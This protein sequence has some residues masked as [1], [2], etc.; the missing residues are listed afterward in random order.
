[1][2]R[3]AL[4]VVF[5]VLVASW[6]PATAQVLPVPPGSAAAGQGQTDPAPPSPPQA[7]PT[8]ASPATIDLNEVPV[9]LERSVRVVRRVTRG[10][11]ADIDQIRRRMP[12]LALGLRAV[13][14]QNQEELR[15]NRSTVVVR[16]LRDLWRMAD[17]LLQN[18]QSTLLE[19]S[20]T[21]E[22]DIATLGEEARYLSA[23]QEILAAENVDSETL[24]TI[25]RVKT[26]IATA[27]ALARDYRNELLGLEAQ[28]A[29]LAIEI[30]L[31]EEELGEIAAAERMGMLRL[32]APP[33]WRRVSPEPQP[34][35]AG[36]PV[37]PAA[38]GT[39]EGGLSD[40]ERAALLLALDYALTSLLLTLAMYVVFLVPF[41]LIRRHASEWIDSD[42]PAV[43]NLGRALERPYSAALLPA[44]MTL[45]ISQGRIELDSLILLLPL[46]RV[47]PRLLPPDYTRALW[48]LAG[49]TVLDAIARVV[50][51]ESAFPAR[52]TE[53]ALIG[54]TAYGLRWL[55]GQLG[56]SA[57][58]RYR[59]AVAG[60]RVALVLLGVAF[61]SEVIGATLLAGYLEN[62]VLKGTYGAV[63]LYGF[64]QMFRGFLDLLIRSSP[65]RLGA[66]MQ[67]APTGLAEKLNAGMR[68]V[69]LVFF[70]LLLIEVFRFTDPLLA[71]GESVMAETLSVGELQFTVGAVFIVI[72]TLVVAAVVSSVLRFFLTAVVYDRMALQRGTGE[73]ISKLL[74]YALLTAGFLFALGAAGIDLNSIAFLVGALGVGIGLG[75]QNIVGNF[76]SGLIL[77]FER[78]LNVGDI[79]SVG[80]VAGAV[81]DIGIRATRIRT[82]DG[83]DVAVPNSTLIS[84]EFTNWSLS[85]EKRRA[86]VKVGVA[87]GTDPERVS[88]ILREVAAGHALVLKD[89]EPLALFTGFGD[90]SLNFVLRYWTFLPDFLNVNSELHAAV[91]RRLAAE[92][93]EIPF[94]QRDVHLKYADAETVRAERGD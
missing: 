74:H 38:A 64:L 21:V 77:L 86:D 66:I 89:P 5:A 41:L 45:A 53:L 39:G 2:P 65:P 3:P 7:G 75:L 58:G 52:V 49:I 81:T 29:E 8:P 55:L 87:Y 46:L 51:P 31:T 43:R 10:L 27:D 68:W 12:D 59:L 19:A 57:P 67:Q 6:I 56:R 42:R 88:R 62:G 80:N 94:P 36:E 69:T 44:F 90:S 84:S 37:G 13:M 83:A 32:D 93:I 18:W 63:L 11:G 70:A 30:Q 24:A 82:W 26:Q 4:I 50:L 54:M 28:V 79:V 40:T 34:P 9:R 14:E 71:Y 35:P 16:Y 76:V 73:V 25:E 92:G 33:I 20:K 85:D 17:R 60:I 22:E 47:I 91:C 72:A 61:I 23:A 1:M 78:P 48:G 15:S